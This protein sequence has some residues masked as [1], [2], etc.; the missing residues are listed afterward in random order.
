MKSPTSRVGTIE[1]D[2]ILN[3]S[4]RN[5]RSRNTIRITGKKLT[6]YSTHH[7][8][9][10]S[11]DR[12]FLRTSM[13]RSHTSPVTTSRISRNRAKFMTAARNSTVTSLQHRQ[14]GFLRDFDGADLLHALFSFFL[15]FEQLALARDVAAVALRQHVLAQRLDVL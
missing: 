11:C 12:R 6:E 3:G 10:A 13:S 1:L 14:E 15:L 9:L 8:C 5:E 4:T 2:G 7:G